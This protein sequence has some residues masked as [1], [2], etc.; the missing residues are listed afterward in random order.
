MASE[1]VRIIKKKTI[2]VSIGERTYRY[3]ELIEE[4]L[5]I[6]TEVIDLTDETDAAAST[7]P[8]YEPT[9][10][11]YMFR[12]DYSPAPTSTTDTNES[13]ATFTERSPTPYPP[14]SPPYS[15]PYNPAISSNLPSPIIGWPENVTYN[16]TYDS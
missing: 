9:T 14:Y 1:M 7:S 3:T 2:V 15:P 16:V 5:N 4:L 6:S 8:R 12:P 13:S 11:E 10:P